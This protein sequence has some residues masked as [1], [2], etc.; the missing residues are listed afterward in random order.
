MDWVQE[1]EWANDQEKI[2]AMQERIAELEAQLKMVLDC[3][4]ATHARHDAKVERLE[5]QAADPSALAAVAMREAAIEA[6]SDHHNADDLAAEIRAIPDPDH[7]ALLRAALELPEVRA[8]RDA[9]K[10]IK[11]D[12][13]GWPYDAACDALAA[14]EGKQ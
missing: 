9:L 11:Q 13:G 3:E 5:A 2:S 10:R 6:V 1:N 12:A 7:A 4:A 14:L 8:M